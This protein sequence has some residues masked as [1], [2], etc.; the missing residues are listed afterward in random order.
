MSNRNKYKEGLHPEIIG[1][2]LAKLSI[3]YLP[4]EE[5]TGIV[6]SYNFKSK[7]SLRKLFINYVFDYF[8]RFSDSDKTLAKKSLQFIISQSEEVP[9]RY[10]LF[11]DRGFVFS[12]NERVFPNQK[13]ILSVLYEVLFSN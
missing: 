1:D 7:E 11:D 6:G 5:W 8:Q 2:V 3:D 9:E 4:A 13:L 10:F 12:D